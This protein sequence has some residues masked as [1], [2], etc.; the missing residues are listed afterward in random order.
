MPIPRKI[1]VQLEV[2]VGT[3]VPN[4]ATM[5]QI[6]AALKAAELHQFFDP[7]FVTGPETITTVVVK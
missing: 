5:D 4:Q 2:Q 3:P 1:K 6:N 7:A